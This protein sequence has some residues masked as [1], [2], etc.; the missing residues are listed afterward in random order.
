M[1]NISR[2][3]MLG[4]V[5]GIGGLTGCAGVPGG[6]TEGDTIYVDPNGSN[7][8]SGAEEEPLETIQKALNVVDPGETIRLN[9]GT[10]TAAWE[11]AKAGEQGK[12]ITITGPKEAILR[13]SPEA[14]EEKY[15]PLRISHSHYRLTGMTIDGL[16][17]PAAP[18]Q[19]ESYAKRL[20]KISPPSDTETYVENVKIAPHGVG[21]SQTKFIQMTR[22]KN[23]AIGPFKVHG[24]AGVN[25]LYGDV[26]SHI[27]EIVYLGTPYQNYVDYDWP[28]NTY[29]ETRNIRIH[30]IDNSHG[31]H[32]A[33]MVDCKEGTRNITIEYCTDGGGTAINEPF[34]TQAIHLR[35]QD[36]TVRW[37]RL[38]G[39]NGNGIA[40]YKP[41]EKELVPT[42]GFDQDAWDSIATNNEI[43]GN[44]IQG[45]PQQ[46][47]G[48]SE[49]TEG[50]QKRL[51][52]NTIQGEP[53]GTPEQDCS[54]AVPRG[55]GI[56]HTGGDSPWA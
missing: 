38:V 29:D 34:S 44:T 18:E 30:H 31:Y 32:H 16:Q 12:P 47:I 39:G 46:A 50:A 43:Y 8:N 54:A 55:D 21:N 2:R 14:V 4:V 28:W 40:V 49:P 27:G 36:S 26:K 48:L 9:P 22:A 6:G 51:C 15:T 17:N 45:F 52:G 7:W 13:P 42:L 3:R 37:N 53:S 41:T 20:L 1:V 11:T 24:P 35:A 56:G 33:E 19:V 25:Y 23:S 5:G 10:Y